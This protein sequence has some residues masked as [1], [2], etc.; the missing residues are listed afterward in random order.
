[1]EHDGQSSKNVDLLEKKFGDLKEKQ[2]LD[3]DFLD[4]LEEHFSITSERI[5]EII[6]RGIT[7]YIFKPSNR[8]IW[9]A[10]GKK[11]LYLIYPDLYCSCYDFFNRVLHH[12]GEVYCKHL[13]AQKISSTL[14]KFDTCE[15]EDEDFTKILE[16]IK[17]IL[18]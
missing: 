12:E 2:K 18:D 14:H 3:S 7:K 4:F 9:I 17:L 11:H 6:Q 16:D 13:L 10:M 15:L 5:M 1:M 8:V